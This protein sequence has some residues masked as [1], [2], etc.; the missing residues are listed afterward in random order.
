MGARLQRNP[1]QKR[2]IAWMRL[3][4]ALQRREGVGVTEMETEEEERRAWTRCWLP[5]RL[6]GLFH[7]GG[8]RGYVPPMEIKEN[9]FF[10][11][12][13]PKYKISIVSMSVHKPT[14]CMYYVKV[15][16]IFSLFKL[17]RKNEI[18]GFT[19]SSSRFL[20]ICNFLFHAGGA[21]H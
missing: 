20:V 6:P 8:R 15:L 2:Q 11:W 19:S 4:Q 21:L 12:S 17:C 13:L 10:Y 3:F 7:F 14:V 5:C 9:N 16:I 1:P 18:N